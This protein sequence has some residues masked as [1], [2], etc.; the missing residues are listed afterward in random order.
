MDP[1]RATVILEEAERSERLVGSEVTERLALLA[2]FD[3]G[4]LAEPGGAEILRLLC[5]RL[6]SRDGLDEALLSEKHRVNALAAMLRRGGTEE[7]Q[8]VRRAVEADYDTPLQRMLDAFIAG[9]RLPVDMNDENDLLAALEVRRWAS[10]ALAQAGQMTVRALEPGQDVIKSR[11]ALLDVTRAIRRLAGAG[12]I[13]RDAELQRLHAYRTSASAPHTTIAENPAMVVYGIGG[14]GKSTL[15]ARFVMD[16]YEMSD[17]DDRSAWAYVDLDRPTLSSCD[18][19]V[20]LTDVIGQVSAQFP[21]YRR[22]LRRAQ[23]VAHLRTKGA[24][25]EASDTAASYRKRAA[26]FADSLR[27]MGVGSLVVVIDTF[28]VLERNHPERD[29]ELYELFATLASQVP[30]LRLVVAGRGPASAFLKRSRRDRQMHLL[31]LADDAAASLL[32]FFAER[33]STPVTPQLD[34]ALAH[35]IIRLVGGIPLTVRLAAAVLA[36]EGANAV[37]DAAVRARA[38]DQVRSEFVRGFL[39]QRILDHVTVDDPVRTDELRQVA[40]A[41]LVLRSITP[42]LIERVLIPSIGLSPAPS[43]TGLFK[44]LASEVTL[45]EREGDVLRLREELRGPALAALALEDPQMIERVHRSAADY[46]ASEPSIE[47]AAVELAYHRLAQGYPVTPFDEATLRQ[48]EPSLADLPEASAALIRLALEN[49]QA[50]SVSEDHAAWEQGVLS[51]ADAALH[52]GQYDRV[53]ELLN[54]RAER[55]DDSELHRLESRLEESLGNLDAAVDAARRDVDAATMASNA[56][57]V[58]AAGVHLAGLLERQRRVGDAE[59]ALREVADK[60]LLAGRPELRLELL[61]NRMTL[62]ERAGILDDEERWSSGLGVRAL[63]QRSRPRAVTSNT[64]M[65][66]LLAAALGREE[67]GR[68][69]EAVRLVGLGHDEDTERVNALVAELAA[70]DAAGSEP[71]QLARASGLQVA[72]ATREDITRAWTALAG[73]GTDAGLLLD[74]VWNTAAPP[75]RVREA[76]RMIYVW[77]G[78][79]S[80]R[81]EAATA[82]P[83]HFLTEIPLDW[84]RPET[85]ELEDIVLT[86]YPSPVDMQGLASRAGL[87]QSRISWASSNRRI[88]RELLAEAS[89]AW[90]CRLA[91]R[92]RPRR[93]RNHVR[94]WADAFARGRELAPGAE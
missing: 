65:V 31:P 51:E 22:M 90:P 74:R 67:P 92:S 64:A 73:L 5:R 25:L 42:Q 72:D 24:G 75:E 93:S 78:M 43:A 39:Y 81:H 84:S 12:C 15:V 19:V 44:D 57:R 89:R 9:A 2:T 82:E 28:E 4:H 60:S 83:M 58:A 55:A 71:G 38:M 45:V 10:R 70:W 88:T 40:R 18:P 27:A 11:L 61:L 86:G 62:M 33:S 49:P 20:V 35:E 53:R 1:E 59:T 23:D 37:T 30:A 21:T 41:G 69:R 56:A 46:F 34:D 32:R 80:D 77:W 26:D 91:R 66:R 76:L 16:L 13:G 8:R 14:I 50:L 63:L 29:T 3:P 79:P 48:L 68:I 54:Q 47:G 87:D 6:P 36:R 85:K 94:P 52:A 17:L 7:L